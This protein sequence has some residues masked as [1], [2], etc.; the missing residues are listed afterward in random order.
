MARQAS[1]RLLK[2]ED[3]QAGR[4]FCSDRYALKTRKKIFAAVSTSQARE[5]ASRG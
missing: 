5:V 2:N 1:A 3:W 4:Q